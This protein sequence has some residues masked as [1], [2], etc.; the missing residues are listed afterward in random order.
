MISGS[1][2]SNFSEISISTP[3]ARIRCARARSDRISATVDF[4][5]M[6]GIPYV[7]LLT[8]RFLAFA[9]Y[10]H[11]LHTMNGNETSCSTGFMA[12][13]CQTLHTL[14]TLHYKRRR[15]VFFRQVLAC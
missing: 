5:S 13:F 6:N 7:L 10:L 9:K 3:R 15:R 4:L 8:A 14:H 1:Q 11:T 12:A 2:S